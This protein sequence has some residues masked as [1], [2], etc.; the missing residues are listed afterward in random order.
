MS[1]SEHIVW[2]KYENYVNNNLNISK[3]MMSGKMVRPELEEEEEEDDGAQFLDNNFEEEQEEDGMILMEFPVTQ[4]LLSSIKLSTNFN[5]W[6]GHTNFNITKD[7]E[8]RLNNVEGVELCKVL[9]RYRF[10]IGV[11]KAFE[12]PEVRKNIRK[13]LN[14]GQLQQDNA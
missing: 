2:E 14:I 11:G 8:Q 7:V 1:K 5:C 10:L 12:F 6:V 13:D 9:T 4:E 3:L